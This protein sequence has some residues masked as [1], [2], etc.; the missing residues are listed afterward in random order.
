MVAQVFLKGVYEDVLYIDV[1]PALGRALLIRHIEINAR[2][3][4]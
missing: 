3:A 4:V 1:K 2:H